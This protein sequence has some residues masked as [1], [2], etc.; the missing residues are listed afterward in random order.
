MPNLIFFGTPDFAV[1][2]LEALRDYNVVGVVCQPDKPAER[3]QQLKAPPVK[4]LALQLGLPVY[5]PAKITPDFIEWFKQQNIDLAIVVA[6]G[7]ILP[8][9]LLD[10]SRLGFIN[11]H[12]SLLPRWRGAAPIQRAIEAG[13]TET[14]VCIMNLVAEMDAGEIYE[15]AKTPIRPDETSGEL[16][17][18]LSA[19]GAE[20]LLKALPGIL[21]QT[22]PKIAQPTEGVTFASKVKKEEA[23]I[24]WSKSAEELVNHCRAMQPWP[25]NYCFYKGKKIRLFGAEISAGEGVK[26]GRILQAGDTLVVQTGSGAIAFTEGQLEGKRRMP[27]ASLLNGFSMHPGDDLC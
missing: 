24:D 15:T 22:L 10:A 5:Q 12:A 11:V 16:F 26:P 17:E 7:K 19:L 25:G 23:L 6:Y 3:G 21:N 2:C 14:G 27:M 13:D 8:Q 9:A 18:R 1:P 4:E 20:T